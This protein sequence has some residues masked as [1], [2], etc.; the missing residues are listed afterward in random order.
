MAFVAKGYVITNMRVIGRLKQLTLMI[1]HQAASYVYCIDLT[2]IF[3]HQ[4]QNH[5]FSSSSVNV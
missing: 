3:I 5:S 2:S 1:D 4:K